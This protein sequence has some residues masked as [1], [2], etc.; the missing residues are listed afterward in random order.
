MF[1]TLPLFLAD[2]WRTLCYGASSMPVSF[3]LTNSSLFDFA[4]RP[5][6]SMALLLSTFLAIRGLKY[7]HN[8]P[9]TQFWP[10]C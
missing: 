4:V 7:L 10:L 5:K 1:A 2:F 6:E 9:R 3:C 8:V